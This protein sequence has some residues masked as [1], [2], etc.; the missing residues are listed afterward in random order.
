MSG[1]PRPA[2]GYAAWRLIADELRSD[3]AEGRLPVG[4]RMPAEHELA[5]RF[6]VNRH[7]VRQGVAAL[8][9][10]GLTEARRGSGTFIVGSPAVVH[11]IGV[12]TRLSNTLGS[13]PSGRVLESAVEE[14]PAEVRAALRLAGPDAVRVETL[15][16][17]DGRPLTRGTHWF[18]VARVPD[19]ASELRRTG[20]VTAALRAL[21]VDDYVRAS[22]SVSARPATAQERA[23]LELAP[24]AAVLVTVSLDTLLD[25]TPLQYGMTRFVA[26]L[27]ML[28][29]E[30]APPA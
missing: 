3:I 25:G 13:S 22:T 6:G 27:V 26:G 5:E 29:I 30:H 12:R 11:R 10:E 20:S 14:P 28:D 21:G 16:I 18:D 4:T 9:A 19:I 7:T 8:A 24:G 2:S 23:E 17:L 1:A 15:R